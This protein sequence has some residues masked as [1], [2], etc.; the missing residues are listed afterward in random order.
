MS[1]SGCQHT[2][3]WNKSGRSVKTAPTSRPPLLPPHIPSFRA[4]VYRFRISYSAAAVGPRIDAAVRD[5]PRGAG[6]ERRRDAN[7]EAAVTVQ[8]RGRLAVRPQS[9]PMNEEHRNTRAVL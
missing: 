2:T 6:V 3:A 8:D 7:V 9:F 5:P 1:R 4:L